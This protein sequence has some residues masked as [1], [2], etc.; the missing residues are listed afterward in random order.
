MRRLE[1]ELRKKSVISFKTFDL[2]NKEKIKN[3]KKIIDSMT[4]YERQ[5]HDFID[6]K[7]KEEKR[8]GKTYK[9]TSESGQV[10]EYRGC[11]GMPE[12]TWDE[13][14]DEF[15]LDHP[16]LSQFFSIS[17][18]DKDRSLVFNPRKV[19]LYEEEREEAE[20][21]EERK[22]RQERTRWAKPKEYYGLSVVQGLFNPRSGKKKYCY[23]PYNVV[24]PL[25]LNDFVGVSLEP[26]PGLDLN[27]FVDSPESSGLRRE[28]FFGPVTFLLNGNSSGMRSTKNIAESTCRDID[29]D[30]EK[31]EEAYQKEVEKMS[32]KVRAEEENIL[33]PK[34]SPSM[35]NVHSLSSVYDHSPYFNSMRYLNNSHVDELIE[36]VHE[37]KRVYRIVGE[38]ISQIYYYLRDYNLNFLSMADEDLYRVN[39]SRCKGQESKLK[40]IEPCLE[41]VD[42][43]K[44]SWDNFPTNRNIEKVKSDFEDFVGDLRI[45]KPLSHEICKHF[46]LQVLGVENQK[47]NLD[48]EDELNWN[49]HLEGFKFSSELS[50]W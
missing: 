20:S 7:F 43:Y 5:V 28:T 39:M 18:S 3:I 30:H 4:H 49:A 33:Q 50:L 24:H 44:I 35:K 46:F 17:L 9:V 16:E 38:A 10:I 34:L 13:I 41:V 6:K 23:T 29:C 21:D 48:G 45:S 8:K 22:R 14:F 25:I 2:L 37:Q 31:T 32:L 26:I 15:D 27:E 36:Q 42:D 40:T 12:I 11:Y 19:R 47:Q 1:G